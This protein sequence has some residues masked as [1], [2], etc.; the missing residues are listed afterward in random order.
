MDK[1]MPKLGFGAMRLPYKG[2]ESNIDIGQV[3]KMVDLFIESGFKYF[4]TAY[5]YHNGKSELALK[6]ALVTRHP[7]GSYWIA[8]KM[9]MWSVRSAQD[10]RRIFNEQLN[11]LGVDYI[12]YYLLHSMGSGS[13]NTAVRLKAYEFCEQLKREGRIRFAGFSF[14]DS[15][16]VLEGILKNHPEMD[17]VQLQINYMDVKMGS[18]GRFYDLA[19]QYN[20]PVIVMEPVKGGTLANLDKP[21][22]AVLKSARPGDS[23]ASWALRYCASLPGV[24]TTLSGMS[25][26]AQV[27]DNI[28]TFI[29]FE[30]LTK[31]EEEIID[32][33]MNAS[34]QSSTIPCTACKYCVDHCPNGIAI[35][36]VF[37]AYNSLKRTGNKFAA[38]SEY[39][40]ISDGHRAGD[41][42]A[43]GECVSYCPQGIQIPEEMANV[44]AVFGGKG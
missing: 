30:P 39:R 34:A 44:E 14:H 12:D 22:E 5:V 29:N 4:D 8:T 40:A 3:K 28:K 10:L 25:D 9:P 35:P 23:M 19:R 26:I 18:S 7:R 37:A 11:K 6:E 43:C 16:D 31:A 36:S 38:N 33:S 1:D 17:F 32:R 24:Y 42:T 27:E 13:E 41:C 2:S 20:K 21:A 15:A